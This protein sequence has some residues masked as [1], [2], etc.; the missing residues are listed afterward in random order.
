M[1]KK[2]I[3]LLLAAAL[4]VTGSFSAGFASEADSCG[5]L[6]EKDVYTPGDD[7]VI[8]DPVLH[9][10]IR[11]A[12]NAIEARPKLTKELV[13]SRQVQDISYELC[14]H[15]EDFEGWEQPYWIEDLT[16]IEYA[17]QAKMVDICY[18]NATEGKKIKDLAPLSKLT[19]LRLLYLKQDGISDISA[20]AALVNLEEL[21]LNAN[22]D[23]SDISAVSGMT[24]MKK[25]S[26]ANNKL[27]GIEAVSGLESLEYLDAAANQITGL[28]DMSRLT[29][30]TY[31]DVSNN[32][33]TNADVE[34]IGKM[35]GL[36]ELNLRGNSGVTD[37]KP[38]ARL[39]YLDETKTFLPVTD[40]EKADL[41]A[42]I[43]VNQ[44][45]N[46]FNISK[47]K[48]SD[49]ENVGKAIEAYEALTDAQKS[50]IDAD[51]VEAAR[52]NKKLVDDGLEPKYYEEY[53]ED[54]E[55]Q[56]VLDRLVI[57]VLDKYGKPMPGVEFVR[58]GMGT[59]SYTSDEEGRI[60]VLH[61]AMDAN[62]DLSVEPKGDAYVAS[63][64][65][66]TY[67]VKDSKTYTINGKRATGFERLS[68]VMIPKE[69]YV[70]KTALK[71]AVES[72]KEL[73]E[74][75]KYTADS[76]SA[77]Q[78]AL[79][80]AEDVLNDVDAAQESVETA[81]ENLKNA[82]QGLQK[83][84]VLT[85]LKLTVKDVNGNLFTRPF[86]FQIYET[87]TRKNAWNQLS[88][89][90][91]GTVYLPV[92]PAWTDGMSWTIEACYEEPYDM[93]AVIVFTT[94]VKNG[95]VYYKTVDGQSVSPDFE[96]TVTVKEAAMAPEWADKERKPDSTVLGKYVEEAKLWEEAGYTAASYA[97]L[98]TAI[99]EAEEILAAQDA[100]QEDYNA[101][102]A[103][104]KKAESE[105][106]K[107]AD[108]RELEKQ[109]ELYYSSDA[110]TSVSWNAYLEER[111]EA[112]GVF[113]NP[114]ATQEEVDEALAALKKAAASLVLK[115]DKTE[116]EE[117][118][119]KAKALNEED[120]VS[121]YEE[122]AKAIEEAQGVYDNP[123]ATQEQ[124]NAA[125]KKLDD[126]IASLQKKPAEP[127]YECYPSVFRALVQDTDGKALSGVKFTI[128][129]EGETH[130]DTAVSDA[131][132]VL[133][134]DVNGSYRKIKATVKMTDGRYTTE[135]EHWYIADG[136]NQW[137]V[138][139]TTVDGED[140]QDGLKLTY[141]LKES[142]DPGPDTPDPD[143]PDP[144]K[145]DPGPDTADK[146]ALKEQ[147]DIAESMANKS[148]DYTEESWSKFQSELT[149]AKEVYADT[150]ATEESISEAVNSLK[151]AREALKQAEKPI[152]C[153]KTNIRILVKDTD[154][155]KITESLTFLITLGANRPFKMTS[156][157][158]V[159]EYQLSDADSGAETIVVEP[160]SGTVTVAGE[161]YIISPQNHE[162]ALNS[163]SL[164]VT[165]TEI[166]GEPLEGTQEVSFTL[167][168]KNTEEP[169]PEPDPDKPGPGVQPTRPSIK[170]SKITIGG[171]SKKIA[172][173]KKIQLSAAVAPKNA[174][175]KT[176]TWTTSNK[177]Y[178][179]V[180]QTGKVTVKKAGVGRT[181][182]VTAAAKDGSGV[183]AAYRIKI[184][185]NAVK[186]IKLKA[187]KS[188][189]AG[190]SLKVKATVK[191]NGKKANKKLAWT[192]S[193]TKYAKVTSS[194][195]VKTY[196]AGKGRTV[197]ITA[198]ATDGSNKKKTVKIKI[199]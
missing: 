97:V 161:E 93:D 159:V 130:T 61:R 80:E 29:N 183:K 30:V 63:P 79:K 162:F 125:V 75:H 73:E 112:Q 153:D 199:K 8:K 113:E 179:T 1:R 172:A 26:V 169:K 9:W 48:A 52:A 50:Y 86:K 70:D 99:T 83:T 118:L 45:F 148:G 151:A 47:M 168:K 138:S 65:K 11:S 115:T 18:T 127:D 135:D 146:E 124:A 46:K 14:A 38:L 156:R 87:G 15:P 197:K 81:V 19:Q 3:S 117:K 42:A 137:I 22:Q 122:L 192:S 96:K 107:R 110:Y 114:D 100:S 10:A 27:S 78:A 157:D 188:V 184:M 165:I 94:G 176:V 144:D 166:D 170:I 134:Y 181:V 111:E 101:A 191:T 129:F 196:K 7:E 4:V 89:A 84:D 116:L 178:A 194:G 98:Q 180:S 171:I 55:E 32:Q 44:L 59:T 145:P 58:N 5:G 74:E 190:K 143:K 136:I 121:G 108:K 62:F 91:T 132:G 28:P 20:L 67:E 82:I 88:D 41:F 34:K 174:A 72:T 17:T 185:K 182:T 92:S 43:G 126:A 53:D 154:G 164:G 152:M 105:L 109:I 102:A 51:R 195:K 133:R 16:G 68:F 35:K 177:K 95:Q 139:M 104:V 186:S 37:L 31:L 120:Y 155:N 85:K 64:E 23:I 39:I 103:A 66:I 198:K 193:N 149:A 12:L 173:G 163:S 119:A 187:A 56:P 24:K 167:Q 60:E 106:V 142:G 160:E 6:L 189:K 131:N 150:E 128:E 90:E 13:G 40:K 2:I 33:L 21:S 71:E 36:K 77:Y 175:N 140:Y 69:E 57:T 123:D 147:I 158:G 54:G 49:S 141:T 76:Y 25:L